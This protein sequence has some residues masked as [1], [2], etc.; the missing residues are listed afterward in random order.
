MGLL[1]VGFFCPPIT[2]QKR[3]DDP[4]LFFDG[5]RRAEFGDAKIFIGC[6]ATFG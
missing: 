3:A 5:A 1:R 6:T 2:H 4:S